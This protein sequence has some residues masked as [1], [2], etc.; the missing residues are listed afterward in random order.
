MLFRKVAAP[1]KSD[2]LMVHTPIVWSMFS[3]FAHLVGKDWN[4]RIPD[5]E[6][7]RLDRE[8]AKLATPFILNPKIEVEPRN[9]WI[10][11]WDFS[12]KASWHVVLVWGNGCK[13]VVWLDGP[14]VDAT[15]SWSSPAQACTLFP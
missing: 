6:M 14:C 4:G 15:P 13:Q 3:F 5:S 7:K 1:K 9:S 10:L 2:E 11:V 12:A 8:R